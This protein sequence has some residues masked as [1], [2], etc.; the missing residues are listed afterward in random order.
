MKL[1]LNISALVLLGALLGWLLILKPIL[2][3][4]FKIGN[5]QFT[6]GTYFSTKRIYGARKLVV[7][8]SSKE[9]SFINR[10]FTGR[11]VYEK[12]E[13]WPDEWEVHPR[14][15]GGRLVSKRKYSVTPFTTSLNKQIEYEIEHLASNV[16][17]KMTLL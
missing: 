13:F 10:L 17:A 15:K 8:N 11:I 14:G 12:N 2:Y 6:N 5:V 9:Q 16:K 7:T 4:T 1:G 3:P